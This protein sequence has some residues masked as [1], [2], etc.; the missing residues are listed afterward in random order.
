MTD[1]VYQLT[2]APLSKRLAR[3]WHCLG[4]AARYADGQPHKVEAFNTQLVVF[5]TESGALAALND[6]CPHM[7]AALS[8]GRVRG[9]SVACP[10]HDWRWGQDGRCTGIPYAKRIPPRART[11]SW[12]LKVVDRVLY[13]WHDP[14]R[15]PPPVEITLPGIEGFETDYADWSYSLHRIATN[16]RE[17]VDNLVDVAH[18]FY[19]HGQGVNRLCAFFGNRFEG[20][21]AWQILE[22]EPHEGNYDKMQIGV[23]AEQVVGRRT[24]TAY[25]GPAYLKSR[26]L[27]PFED[28][29]TENYII[30]AQQPINETEFDLHMLITTRKRP[31]LTDEQNNLRAAQMAEMLRMGTL[32]DVH[33]WKTKTRIDN[34]LLCDGDGPIYQLR[35]WYEQFFVNIADVTPQMTQ[36]EEIITD[37]R[38][39]YEVWG[40]Q[41]EERIAELEA[42]GISVPIY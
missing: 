38:Y 8:E 28:E 4:P 40:R 22:S 17:L 5:R 30:L 35:R 29:M 15:K 16:P 2:A 1:D 37:T 25:F 18:F 7:G 10:F 23:A 19:V 3:G 36:R 39:A 11:R 21:V 26:L 6:F 9:D 33:I 34:P 13:V 42:A 41:S 27:I 20:H 31:D 12:P 24:E 14:E 32:Q